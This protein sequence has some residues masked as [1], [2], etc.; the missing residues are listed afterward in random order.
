MRA[1]RTFVDGKCVDG[2]MAATKRLTEPNCL[3]AAWTGL[4]ASAALFASGVVIAASA[5][6]VGDA[7]APSQV[8]KPESAPTTL[9]GFSLTTVAAVVIA[10]VVVSVL[11]W[12][13]LKGLLLRMYAATR[14]VEVRLKVTGWSSGSSFGRALRGTSVVDVDDRGTAAAPGAAGS[15]PVAAF[16]GDQIDVSVQCVKGGHLAGERVELML[17]QSTDA[18]GAASAAAKG[19]SVLA[20]APDGTRL[21]SAAEHSATYRATLKPQQNRL[22]CTLGPVTAPGVFTVCFLSPR[23]GKD[24]VL[25]TTRHVE[26]KSQVILPSA[27][28]VRW[29][30]DLK[31]MYRTS[32]V[33]HDGDFIELRPRGAG[34]AADVFSSVPVPLGHGGSSHVVFSGTLAPQTP[35]TYECVYVSGEDRKTELAR[36]P[37][38]EVEGADVS[39]SPRDGG[40]F[41]LEPLVARFRASTK[42]DEYDKIV[43]SPATDPAPAGHEEFAADAEATT[44]KLPTVDFSTRSGPWQ[45]ASASALSGTHATVTFEGRQAPA[46]P[47]VYALYYMARHHADSSRYV[48]RGRSAPFRVHAPRV[49]GEPTSTSVTTGVSAS[50]PASADGGAAGAGSTITVAGHT[51][52]RRASEFFNEP[53]DITIEAPENRSSSDLLSLVRDDA[54]DGVRVELQ[55]YVPTKPAG[56]EG[57]ESRRA[58]VKFDGDNVPTMPGRYRVLYT[59]AGWAHEDAIEAAVLDVRAPTLTRQEQPKYFK[60]AV[61]LSIHTAPRHADGDMVALALEG[62]APQVKPGGLL[63]GA[64]GLFRSIPAGPAGASCKLFFEDDVAPPTPG[65]WQAVYLTMV[66][67]APRE[68][69]RSPAFTVQG[70]TLRLRIDRDPDDPKSP[71]RVVVSYITSPEHLGTDWIGLARLS[72]DPNTGA[73]KKMYHYVEAGKA[74]GDIVFEPAYVPAVR[75]D[76]EAVYV[77]GEGSDFVARS[78]PF[79]VNVAPDGTRSFELGRAPAPVAAASTT[80]PAALPPARSEPAPAEEQPSAATVRIDASPP[81][82]THHVTSPVHA[83]MSTMVAATVLTT[84]PA[85][86]AMAGTDSP[87]AGAGAAGA[88]GYSGGSSPSPDR[89]QSSGASTGGGASGGG[90][91]SSNPGSSVSGTATAGTSAGAAAG[92]GASGSADPTMTKYRKMSNVG[93][94]AGAVRQAMMKDGIDAAKIDAFFGV[95]P[96]AARSATAAMSKST[97]AGDWRADIAR[98]RASKPAGADAGRG[99][100]GG[101]GGRDAIVAPAPAATPSPAPPPRGNLME[102]IQARAAERNR[103]VSS[104]NA[105]APKAAPAGRPAAAAAGSGGVGD[106]FKAGLVRMRNARGSGS[107]GDDDEWDD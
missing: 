106:M 88:D 57:V 81:T 98:R 93:L 29:R 72:S 63:F 15:A 30:E 86:A 87:A 31:V 89:Q 8:P 13:G 14:Q 33:H 66:G 100:S 9:F 4:V 84:T 70:P 102:E 104:G 22:E 16:V 79:K 74:T 54:P 43:L 39:L 68:L 65:A 18:A 20:V 58:L 52:I 49:A 94:P 10:V 41:Y 27:E 5:Q 97:A 60:E 103:R 107:G 59:P 71:G 34:A 69:A 76:F 56:A 53:L 77:L 42:A 23:D 78:N 24:R 64:S 90:G 44:Q 48:V 37:L 55:A 17:V 28:R 91:A 2:A 62:E 38:I 35:G 6:E 36:S 19:A 83:P 101:G 92:G 45:W 25:L 85:T 105:K 26:V 95:A 3:R 32:P 46:K 80:G 1:L 51:G 82:R 11:A 21:C 50:A 40:Q 67:G 7:S 75:G 96:T 73:T 61:G 12:Q 47:G 99:G